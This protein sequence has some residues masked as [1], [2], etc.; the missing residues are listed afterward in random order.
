MF[1]I[2]DITILIVKIIEEFK[3]DT[4]FVKYL[5]FILLLLKTENI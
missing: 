2:Q 3:G 1:L 4:S 5:V